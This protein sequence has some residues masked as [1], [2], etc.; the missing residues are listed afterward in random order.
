M[1]NSKGWRKDVWRAYILSELQL[2]DVAQLMRCDKWCHT[3]V[4]CGTKQKEE[5]NR[6]KNVV[7][8]RHPNRLLQQACK[9]TRM[10]M[11]ELA[12]QKGATDWNM[13]LDRCV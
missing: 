13:A 6:W 10:D 11:I 4:A 2:T 3:N 1:N 9:E 8:T 5:L 7:E 12:I